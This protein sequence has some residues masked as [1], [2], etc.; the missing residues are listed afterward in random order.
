MVREHVI[1]P[2]SGHQVCSVEG[3]LSPKAAVPGENLATTMADDW[4]LE[5]NH[6]TL[7][8]VKTETPC[9]LAAHAV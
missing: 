7:P 4:F 2:R 8:L 9:I 6:F 1:V 5:E 3:R